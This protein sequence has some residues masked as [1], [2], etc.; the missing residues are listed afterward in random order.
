MVH[1]VGQDENVLAARRV[2]QIGAAFAG[3]EPLR[4]ERQAVIVRHVPVESGI[5]LDDAVVRLA[6]LAKAGVDLRAELLGGGH[7][8]KGERGCRD[9]PLELLVKLNVL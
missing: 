2:F 1:D 5:A 7:D 6:E 8:H 4:H 3:L 9:L